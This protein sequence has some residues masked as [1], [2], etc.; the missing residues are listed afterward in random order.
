MQSRKPADTI[1][2]VHAAAFALPQIEF[3]TN[4]HETTDARGIDPLALQIA[5]A[6]SSGRA[7]SATAARPK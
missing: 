6:F 5:E 4:R 1:P 7:P 3:L 2:R